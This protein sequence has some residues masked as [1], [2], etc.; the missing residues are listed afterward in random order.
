MNSRIQSRPRRCASVLSVAAIALC[1]CDSSPRDTATLDVNEEGDGTLSLSV[2]PA[3]QVRAV[4]PDTLVPLVTINNDEATVA[5]RM[6]GL[7]ESRVVVPRG[8]D[9]VVNIRWVERTEGA[10]L[11]L[12]DANASIVSVDRNRTIQIFTD[13]YETDNFDFDNDGISNLAEL[14]GDSDP[15]NFNDP[16]SDFAAVDIPFIDPASAP[17]IDGIEDLVWGNATIRDR[18]GDLLQIDNLMID[19]GATRLD[20][21]TEYAWKAMHDGENLYLLIYGEGRNGQSPFGDSSPD[22]WND[23]AIDV[24][25]DPDNSKL[26]DYDGIDDSHLLLPLLQ[27]D[28]Q[29]NR[30]G[31]VGTRFFTGFNSVV[32]D[33]S[34]VEFVACPCPGSR[35]VWEIRMGLGANRMELDTVIGFEIQLADDNDGDERDAKWGWFH[36][37]RSDADVDNT[38]QNPAFMS[39]MRLVPSLF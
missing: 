19:Q 23:D 3:L 15:R 5:A 28:G 9:V 1:A 25:W 16:G 2:P 33:P 29:A 35:A 38:W 21:D 31:Q 18:S 37:S 36:P 22:E 30:S 24:F 26:S 13:G 17:L 10:D 20:G 4:D 12:A 27:L 6:D 8:S 7:W 14:I 39:T 11:L 32:L 34:S